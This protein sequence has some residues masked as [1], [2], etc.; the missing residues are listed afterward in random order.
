M[1]DAKDLGGEEGHEEPTENV[2]GKD[3]TISSWFTPQTAFEFG[4]KLATASWVGGGGNAAA[5]EALRA[6]L[7]F[8][9]IVK[10]FEQATVLLK[11]EPTLVEVSPPTKYRNVHGLARLNS[12][13]CNWLLCPLLQACAAVKSRF[14]YGNSCAY[15]V[16]KKQAD[17]S[18]S[19]CIPVGR[20]VGF[21]CS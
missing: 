20:Q 16:S 14:K 4:R 7:P 13:S 9:D 5:F 11:S 12:N 21:V 17:C 19:M 15:E 1:T 8:E 10:I 3:A 18:V 2:T 6:V